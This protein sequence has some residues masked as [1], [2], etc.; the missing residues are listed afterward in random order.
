MNNQ[1]ELTQFVFHEIGDNQ[2]MLID[3]LLKECI[4]SWDEIIN[5]EADEDY[6]IEIMEWWLATDWMID[7]LEAKGEIILKTDFGNWWGRT[8]SGQAIML[9]EVIEKIYNE[10]KEYMP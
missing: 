5:Y 6:P 7:K 3:K 10:M 1:E 2:T 4:F 8:S 9:D